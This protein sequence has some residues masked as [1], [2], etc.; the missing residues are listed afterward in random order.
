MRYG[1][2]LAAQGSTFAGTAGLPTPKDALKKEIGDGDKK[3]IEGIFQ[4][5]ETEEAIV[6]NGKLTV[7]KQEGRNLPTNLLDLGKKIV[8]PYSTFRPGDRSPLFDILLKGLAKYDNKGVKRNVNERL[9]GNLQSLKQFYASFLDPIVSGGVVPNADMINQISN[10]Y[11]SMNGILQVLT[12]GEYGMMPD[13]KKMQELAAAKQARMEAEKKASGGVVYAQNGTLVNYQPRGTDTVPAM[14][15]PGEFVV[16]R[17]ATQRNLPLLKSINSNRYQTGGIVQP[18]Y[19]DIGSMVSGAS[20]AISGIAGTLGVKVDIGKLEKD[21]NTA[22][23]NGAK[24]LSGAIKFANSDLSA[25]SAF[26]NSL[27]SV[28]SQ[29]SQINIPPEIKFSMQ[30]VQVNITGAKGLTDA[31]ESIVNGAIAKAFDDFL[32]INDLQ[33]TYKSPE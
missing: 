21:I 20:K 31:A 26:T 16:N 1:Q 6:A 25:L 3:T 22:M 27:K 9:V 7:N 14:L 32:S 8:N 33:G 13:A 12:N 15:T 28:I 19:H 2:L 23:S 5:A 29:I 4:K 24:L 30:P 11:A 18:Q 10:Q 17:Q